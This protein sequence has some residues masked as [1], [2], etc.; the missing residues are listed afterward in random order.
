MSRTGTTLCPVVAMLRYLAVR[1]SS[2]GPLLIHANGLPLT[3]GQ[4]VSE[5]KKSLQTAQIDLSR[6]SGHSFWIDAV[7]AAVAAGVLAYFIKMLGRWESEAYHLY[8]RTPPECLEA[9]THAADCPVSRS[10]FHVYVLDSSSQW[11]VT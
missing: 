10:W 7:S 6:Y 3:R 8:T 2:D 5:V 11:A 1:G 4:F 9:V